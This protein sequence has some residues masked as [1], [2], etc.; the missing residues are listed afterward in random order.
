MY[1]YMES[2]EFSAPYEG[3]ALQLQLKLEASLGHI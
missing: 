1:S 2:G 3:E